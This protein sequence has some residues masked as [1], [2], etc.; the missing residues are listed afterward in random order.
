MSKDLIV[1]AADRQQEVTIK[2]LLE[3]RYHSLGIRQITFDIFRHPRKDPGIFHEAADFLA[4]YQPPQYERALVVLDHAW[5][6]APADPGLMQQQLKGTLAR[7]W[8]EEKFE[9]VVIVP[10]LEIWVWAQS[11]H[12][13]DILRM[14]WEDIHA[15][16]EEKGYWPEGESKPVY[17]KR[18]LEDILAQQ[19]RPR[20]SAIFQELAQ[21]VGLRSCIDPAF[22]HMQRVLAH[23]FPAY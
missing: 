2:T 12:V 17:P 6:G 23:W 8:D 20:S 3:K 10:E 11:S 19:M 7:W 18:L 9:V 1:L 4:A 16:A 14:P 22:T 13:A 15:M 5:D 21:Q